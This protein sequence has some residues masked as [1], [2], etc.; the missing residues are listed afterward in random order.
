MLQ[1]ERAKA[2]TTQ[3]LYREAAA[4]VAV[5]K[6]RGERKEEQPNGRKSR[7]PVPTLKTR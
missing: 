7:G 5:A 6:P 4:Q 2:R 3:H 1:R